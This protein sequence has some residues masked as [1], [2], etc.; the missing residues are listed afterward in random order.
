MIVTKRSSRIDHMTKHRSNKIK[1]TRKGQ[2]VQN[3]YKTKA[4][5]VMNLVA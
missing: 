3:N 1:Y 4:N 5:M 2:H